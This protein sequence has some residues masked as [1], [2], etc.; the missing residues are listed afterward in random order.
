MLALCTIIGATALPSVAFAQE[1]HSAGAPS[2]D[3]AQADL[4]AIWDDPTFQKQFV[5]GYGINA[6]IEPRVTKE[7]VA[8]LEKVR[9][10]VAENRALAETALRKAMKPDCSA[11]LDFTLGGI[12][13]QEERLDEALACYQKAVE[14]FPSFRR[15]YR[16]LGL[17]AVRKSDFDGAI[18]AFNRM[19]ELGGADAY[20]YGLLAFAHS[21]KQDFQPAEAAYRNALL[22]QPANTEW[23]LGLTRTVFKQGK[24]QDAAALLDSLIMQY[25]DKADFWSL[26]AYTFIGMKEPMKAATNLE[27]LDV[28]GKSTVDT[29]YTLGDIY[30]TENVASLAYG[31]Y[32]RAVKKTVDQPSARALRCAEQ[33]AARGGTKEARDLAA[34]VK[35]TWG[36]QMAD[37]DKTK[38]LKLEARLAMSAGGGD[39]ATAAIL[40]EI[41]R[42]DPLDGE[43]LMLLG[44]H[45]NR[46]GNPEKAMLAYE[47]AANLDQFGA[48][49]RVKQAQILVSQSRP[50][51]A[52]PLLRQAQEIKPREDVA[53]YLEQVER[54]AK[55]RR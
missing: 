36:E 24:Y 16:N 52:I 38:L 55:V 27:A 35:S 49:A 50:A 39:D 22:L 44:Q 21:S 41:L 10:L 28:L 43:A 29:L 53:R 12:L 30:L 48:S 2:T 25:P 20:S 1:F 13:F 45:Y 11:I 31:A 23:R 8:I 47:R 17:I 19:I 33:L 18:S 34:L 54:L 9:P 3:V 15:A 40:E 32:E 51:E 46:S 6:E 4:R 5:G 37:A 14:K 26:Q 7:E 42:I